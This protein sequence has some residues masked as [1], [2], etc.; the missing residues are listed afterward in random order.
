MLIEPAI[1]MRRTKR[2]SRNSFQRLSTAFHL[3]F[4]QR[5]SDA[6]QAMQGGL[7]GMLINKQFVKNSGQK[8]SVNIRPR[9]R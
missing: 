1:Q 2:K 7:S 8:N 6:V 4:S 3:E 9:P 5:S